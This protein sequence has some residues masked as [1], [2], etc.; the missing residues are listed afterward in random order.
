MQLHE[1]KLKSLFKRSR[2]REKPLYHESVKQIVF[3]AFPFLLISGLGAIAAGFVLKNFLEI[4]YLVP[5]IFVLLPALMNLK[6]A[7]AASLAARL[8]T[9]YH[10]GMLRGKQKGIELKENLVGALLTGLILSITSGFFSFIV[11]SSFGLESISLQDFLLVSF[12][13]SVAGITVLTAFTVLLVELAAR[14]KLDPNN[15]TF[16][17]VSMVG[18][19]TMVLIY[20]IAVT[21]LLA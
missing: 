5:G 1:F 14:A 12:A 6:G 19:V 16:P 2:Y 10:L 15:V 9:T 13:A 11:A 7:V 20:F 21:E 18:D 3:Q 17:L 4:I 8:G